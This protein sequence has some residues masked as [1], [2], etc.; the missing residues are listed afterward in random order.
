MT[1]PASGAISMGEVNTELRLSGTALISLNDRSVRLLAGM[2]PTPP[3]SIDMNTLHGKAWPWQVNPGY[4]SWQQIDPGNIRIYWTGSLIGE[5][6]TEADECQSGP[7]IYY[8]GPIYSGE[9]Y[10]IMRLSAP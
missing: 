7:Y 2:Y 5:F 8:R 6:I 10:Y 3:A 4:T 1:L 9:Y